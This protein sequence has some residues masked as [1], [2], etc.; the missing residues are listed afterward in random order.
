VEVPL[1]R[2]KRLPV[3]VTDPPV[4]EEKG[5]LLVLVILAPSAMLKPSA[6]SKT[7]I[8]VPEVTKYE[9]AKDRLTT[10]SSPGN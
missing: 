1:R 4:K 8:V 5:A 6:E 7:L 2:S 10:P 9:P 3:V